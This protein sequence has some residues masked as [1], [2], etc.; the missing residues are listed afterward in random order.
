MVIAARRAYQDLIRWI[1]EARPR[2]LV[3]WRL[4]RRLFATSS[5][6]ST[7]LLGAIGLFAPA[8]FGAPA[9]RPRGGQEWWAVACLV[10]LCLVVLLL[11]RSSMSAGATRIR[12][13][14]RGRLEEHPSFE[15]SVSALDSSPGALRTRFALGWVWGPM[16]AGVLGAIFAASAVYFVVDAILARFSIG[17]Q[18]LLL[19]VVNA[20]LSLIIFRIAAKRLS[21]WR[22]SFAVH[23]AVTR[24]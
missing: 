21:V 9:S 4:A 13:T 2:T 8:R 6:A 7:V 5:L 16:A 1:K 10:G 14:F 12:E 22:L 17:W 18:Q 24:L 11:S 20:A 23:R 15:P 3:P 19:A